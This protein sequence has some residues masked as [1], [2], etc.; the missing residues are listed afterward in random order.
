MLLAPLHFGT[1]GACE[2]RQKRGSRRRCVATGHPGALVVATIL[3]LDVPANSHINGLD[4]SHFFSGYRLRKATDLASQDPN[5][6]P[7]ATDGPV[8]SS[9]G[10]SQF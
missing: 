5:H 3:V 9:D 10:Q 4:P 1:D 2:L 6:Q 7:G 8:L